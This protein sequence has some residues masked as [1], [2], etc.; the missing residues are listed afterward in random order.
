MRG[1]AGTAWAP[2]RTIPGA[3]TARRLGD[4]PGELAGRRQPPERTR[5]GGARRRVMH[6]LVQAEALRR[7][8]GA[9]RRRA[10]TCSA[11]AA[12]TAPCPRPATCRFAALWPQA[13]N[14]D[15]PSVRLNLVWNG[16]LQEPVTLHTATLE[17]DIRG[18]ACALVGPGGRNARERF[19]RGIP[20]WVAVP[21][22]ELDSSWRC[23]AGSSR[24]ATPPRWSIPPAGE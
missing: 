24:R 10:S 13:V 12:R 14:G 3:K 11:S 16:R 2:A 22:R 5:P 17:R 8:P 21:Q 4:R 6:G 15:G 20:A 18:D 19:G 23:A 9:C 1:E 7:S